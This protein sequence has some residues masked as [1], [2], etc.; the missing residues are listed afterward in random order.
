MTNFDAI[1]LLLEGDAYLWYANNNDAIFNFEIFSKLF[2]QQFKSTASSPTSSIVGTGTL[3][4]TVP[5]HLTTSHLQQT[6]ADEIIKKPTYFRGSQEDVHDWLDKLEQRFKM[7][8]WDDEQKLRYISIHLQDDA[9][10]W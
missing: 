10:R 8:N 9:Y 1:L 6:V 7:A 4:T 3:V 5:D 2:L